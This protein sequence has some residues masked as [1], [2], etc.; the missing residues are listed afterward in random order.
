MWSHNSTALAFSLFEW[1][2]ELERWSGIV[3]WTGIVITFSSIQPL[4]AYS[5]SKP[6]SNSIIRSPNGTKAQHSL[7]LALQRRQKPLFRWYIK[8]CYSQKLQTTT[9]NSCYWNKVS[10]AAIL[11]KAQVHL[12]KNPFN[13]FCSLIHLRLM[14]IINI[15][16]AWLE[17][18]VWSS[19]DV[20]AEFLKVI[21]CA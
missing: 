5:T 8:L 7:G 20:K 15:Y 21:N 2:P 6:H 9:F 12:K 14:K 1:R 16:S 19:V 3:A 11:L 10:S 4:S 18:M 17:K 13:Q